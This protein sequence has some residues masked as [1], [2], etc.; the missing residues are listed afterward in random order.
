MYGCESWT[1]NKAVC[2]KIDAFEL[3]LLDKTLESPLDRKEIKSVNTKEIIPEYSLKRL[4]LKLKLQ[5]LGHLMWR[6]D[7]LKKTLILGK[8]ES[9]RRR[10]WQRMRW[11][12]TITD[13]VE[14]SLRKLWEMERDL[15][16]WHAAVNGVTQSWTWP[17]AAAAAVSLQSCLTLCDPI[18]GSPPGFLSLGFSRQEHWSGLPLPSPMHESEKWKWSC[19]VMSDSS[20]PM[21][22]SPPGSSI[23]GIF[24]AKVLE[25]GAIAFSDWV[26]KQQKLQGCLPS[27][28]LIG[29][30]LG[31]L[32]NTSWIQ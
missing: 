17:S 21:D 30:T 12:D 28:L 23:R 14:M 25:W 1:R 18:D 5:Y 8:I 13:S 11:L 10:G 31:F 3:W 22:R 20:D 4:M 24:Q 32:W 27:V 16:A 15:D 2:Q 6:A 9:R 19:S 26:T 29:W 7:L